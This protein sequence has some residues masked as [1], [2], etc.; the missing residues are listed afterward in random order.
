[1]AWVAVEDGQREVDGGCAATE[2]AERHKGAFYSATARSL[3]GA[4][5]H[6]ALVILCT[7]ITLYVL[8]HDPSGLP[9]LGSLR[10]GGC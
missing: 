3:M 4:W 9:R 8:I 2:G 10:Q 6:K 7:I 1:M 5:L